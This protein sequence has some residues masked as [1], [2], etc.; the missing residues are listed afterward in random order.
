MY[1]YIYISQRIDSRSLKWLLMW[2]WLF[3]Q[4][5]LIEINN[6]EN[7]FILLQWLWQHMVFCD[8]IKPLC[9][10]SWGKSSKECVWNF[11]NW[12]RCIYVA[13]LGFLTDLWV[14][15]LLYLFCIMCWNVQLMRL[16]FFFDCSFV[17]SG[18]NSTS[19]WWGKFANTVHP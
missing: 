4:V 2:H 5:W 6:I 19:Q 7:C 13:F 9:L 16:D 3:L 11:F 18:N 8:E 17:D 14:L 15:F 12:S 10:N 1:I